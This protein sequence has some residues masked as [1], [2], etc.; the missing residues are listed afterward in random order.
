MLPLA[1][2]VY[3][4]FHGFTP[5]FAG[6]VGLALT[7]ILVLGAALAARHLADGVSLRVL[8]RASASARRRS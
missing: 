1:A 4:L 2:L 7:A 5:M 3:M 8:D 6:I